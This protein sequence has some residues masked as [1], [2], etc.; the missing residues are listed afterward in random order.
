[1][2]RPIEECGPPSS[3]VEADRRKLFEAYLGAGL[4]GGWIQKTESGWLVTVGLV[5]VWLPTEEVRASSPAELSHSLAWRLAMWQ[6]MV[7]A[8]AVP[9]E[10]SEPEF[11][12]PVEINSEAE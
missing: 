12:E 10:P 9:S 5:T 4:S 1:M 11:E 6:A 3:E 8:G 7:T 2:G